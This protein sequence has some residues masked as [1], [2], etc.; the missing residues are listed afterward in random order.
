MITL[1]DL[2]RMDICESIQTPPHSLFLQVS[3]CCASRLNA[4]FSLMSLSCLRLCDTGIFIPWDPDAQPGPL[5]F[6][7]SDRPLSGLLN[8][9]QRLD[10]I[11]LTM[12]FSTTIGE[13]V[14]EPV[15]PCR[16]IQLIQ[17]T[18]VRNLSSVSQDDSDDSGS[19]WNFEFPRAFRVVR[20]ETRLKNT[21]F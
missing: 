8:L 1:N 21:I 14:P 15:D 10:E 3:I 13:D 17:L 11:A 12:N 19:D 20:D 2:D 5:G 16:W 6:S 9:N 18:T 7:Q 4:N